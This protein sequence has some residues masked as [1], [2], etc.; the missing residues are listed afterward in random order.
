MVLAQPKKHLAAMSNS[1]TNLAIEVIEQLFEH[2]LQHVLAR[3]PIA[4]L[5][6]ILKF[7]PQLH[8]QEFVEGVSGLNNRVGPQRALSMYVSLAEL[9]FA[10]RN[11]MALVSM[12]K[13]LTPMAACRIKRAA[14]IEYIS[15]CHY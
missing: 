11:L 5:H 6:Q 14:I 12:P 3:V 9:L 8:L 2:H 1:S 15:F 7:Q 13:F 4:L 10:H